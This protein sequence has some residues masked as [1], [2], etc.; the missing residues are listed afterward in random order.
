MLGFGSCQRFALRNCVSFIVAF[1][2]LKPTNLAIAQ[3]ASTSETQDNAAAKTLLANASSDLHLGPFDLHPRLSAGMTYDDNLLFSTTEKETDVEWMIQ[4]ALQAVAGDDAALIAY[5]DQNN[6]VFS[7]SPGSLIIQDPDN[8]PGELLIMDYA[9]RFQFFDKY[10]ANN[11]I[12]E[13]ATVDFLW[14]MDKLILECKQDYQLVNTMVIEANQR[15]TIET[16]P[17]TFSAAYQFGEKT[18]MEC[19]LRRISVGYDQ[20]GLTGYTEYNTE[21]WFNYQVDPNL[22]ASL[23]ALAGWDIVVGHQ[24]QTY[25]QLRARVRNSYTY[26]LTFDVS[27]GGELRQYENGNPETLSPV[28]DIAGQYQ[29]GERTSLR[30]AGYRQLYAAVFDG[31]NYT[32]TGVTLDVQQG[33]TDRFTADLGLGYN[34]VSFVAVNNPSTTH[35]EGYYSARITLNAKIVSHLKGQVFYQML[36]RQSQVDGSLNDNQAGVQFAWSF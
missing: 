12:N 17:T 19:D 22:H 1:S 5:R 32:M 7:L 34:S 14:P 24:D 26:K 8:R 30:L 27:V 33:I 31:Y 36:N 21:T 35:P 18:S 29:L 23:G 10:T 28:F 4:P 9:P 15:S 6:N 13:F 3:D 25:E 20:P 16:I 11:F 2:L